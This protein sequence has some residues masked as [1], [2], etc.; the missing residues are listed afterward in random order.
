MAR[1]GINK[2]LV[3]KARNA[4]MAR[5]INPSIDAIRIE[6]GNTGSKSTIHR[7]LQ[8]IESSDVRPQADPNRLSDELT[9]LVEQLLKRLLEEGNEALSHA[10]SQHE[11]ELGVLH[12]RIE[13]LEAEAQQKQREVDSRDAALGSLAEELKVC[14]SS[15]QVEL[16]RNARISQSC[17][18]LEVRVLE[19][20]QQL[21]SLEEKHTHARDAMEHYRNAIKDQREQDHRR[22]ETQLQQLQHEL[23]QV[24]QTLVVR[25]DELTRLNRDNERL[26]SE[27]RQNNRVSHQQ[28]D[29]IRR[30]ESDLGIANMAS[31]RA[32][33]AKE[34]LQEQLTLLKE[35]REATKALNEETQVELA[36]LKEAL[37]AARKELEQ[38]RST[39]PSPDA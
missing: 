4:L 13:Y 7:Y 27:A 37:S 23:T 34:L 29:T 1:G 9:G 35:E 38:C 16:T 6:L 2:A 19:K 20:D 17:T 5:G 31:A 8:E 32:E 33:G 12:K 18:D 24:Q 36:G 10:R 22:H 39:A 25:Q 11:Q 3:L 26:L 21:K 28:H 30:M 15:L 14:Q